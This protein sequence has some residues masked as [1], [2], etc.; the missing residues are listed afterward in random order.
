[1]KKT[2]NRKRARS[3]GAQIDRMKGRWPNL[4]VT[5]K[6]KDFVRWEGYLRGFQKFY[7]IE[8]I[9]APG[10]IDRPYVKLLNPQL[11][12]REDEDF[13]KIPHLIYDESAPRNS[14]LCLFDDEGKE[15]TDK[16]LI[17]DTTIPWTAQWLYYY[18]LWHFDGVWRG[19]GVG[20]ESVAKLKVQDVHREKSE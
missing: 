17:A 9:W 15:W 8:V 1:M 5:R 10:I 14:Y 12:P 7:L 19:G 11:E 4:V 16:D 2:L 20:A 13:E 6:N 3:I 18:E